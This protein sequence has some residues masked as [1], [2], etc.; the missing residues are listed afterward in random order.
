M[1]AQKQL[2]T[3]TRSVSERRGMVALSLLCGSL[4]ATSAV[5]APCEDLKRQPRGSRTRAT[6]S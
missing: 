6:T 3:E 4:L 5:A 1:T 2:R